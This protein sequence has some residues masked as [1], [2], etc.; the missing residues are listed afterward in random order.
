[1]AFDVGT[2]IGYLDLDTS[3]FQKGF[4][5][6][7]SDLKTFNDS[8]NSTKDRTFAL[9]SA[10]QSVGSTLTQSVTLPLVGIGTAAFA[11]GAEFESQMSRVRAIGEEVGVSF[12]ELEQQ[13]LDLGATTSFSASEAA[14]GMEQL[15]S[16]GFTT[17]EIY[18]AMPGLLD[19]AASSGADLATASE[20]AAAALNG[21]GLEA[22]QAGH[23]ADVFAEAAARTNAQVEDMGEA[24]KYIA[25]VA[26]AMGLSLEET[27][28][29]VGIL[30]D[31]GI[32]GSQAG[33]TL[34]GALT[35]LTKPTKDA[36]AVM[37][38]YGMSFFDA[39]GKMLPLSGVIE[40]LKQGLSGLTDQQRNQALTTLFGQEA[41]SGMLVLMEAGPDKLSELTE[42][43]E[44]VEGSAK[45]MAETMMDNAKGAIEEMFG[46]LETAAINI[47]KIL[48]PMVTSVV[49]WITGLINSFNQM[50]T[51]GQTVVVTIAAI[52]AAAGPLL[53]VLGKVL[54]TISTFPAT[55]T[56]IKSGLA[57]V[58]TGFTALTGAL[59][60]ISAPVLAV[61]AVIGVL[62]AAFKHL[63]DTNEEF[64]SRLTA[65]W[66]DLKGVFSGFADSLLERINSLG[67]EFES[68]TEVLSALWTGFCE[69]LGPLFEGALEAVV[70]VLEIASKLLIGV[71]DLF[72]GLFT[73]DFD[74]FAEGLKGIWDGLWSFVQ[75]IL[76]GAVNLITGIVDTFLGWFDTTWEETWQGV[77]DFF[78]NVWTGITEF[79][80]G[81]LKGISEFFS[82]TI[83]GILTAAGNFVEGVIGFFAKLPSSIWSWLTGSSEKIGAW[84]GDLT[85]EAKAVD[86]DVTTPI[87]VSFSDLSQGIS[88][89]LD[90]ILGNTSD[91]VTKMTQEAESL[92]RS[93]PTTLQD[94]FRSIAESI[95][96]HLTQTS[97]AIESWGFNLIQLSTNI[98]S[99]LLAS[100]QQQLLS[101]QTA[102]S[103][104]LE[105]LGLSIS[106][107]WEQMW[108]DTESALLR[109]VQT[110]ITNFD[111]MRAH[112][113]QT[114]TLLKTSVQQ[115][116]TSMVSWLVTNL[117][118]LV[119]QFKS[120]NN[121]LRT[122]T[123]TTW[124]TM[125][126]TVSTQFSATGEFLLKTLDD[127]RTKMDATWRDISSRTNNTV[128]SMHSTLINGF[129][130]MSNNIADILGTI[131]R[132]VN[133]MCNAVISNCISAM[134]AIAQLEAAAARSSTRTHG[135]GGGSFATGLDYVPR[136]MIVKVHQG[137]SIRT[138]QQ[139]RQDKEQGKPET[140]TKQPLTVVLEVDGRT[141]GKVAISNINDIADTD[142][143]VPLKV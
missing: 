77:S 128:H 98:S 28:A 24:M 90:T 63:W 11:V 13:A 61:V 108:Y 76:E 39:Q 104:G 119:S 107:Y 89:E 141:L 40:Q 143:R 122:N 10:F 49:Q 8:A 22:D 27:A 72:I 135:G 46:A 123:E 41:L 92:G 83:G 105:S 79:F 56:A 30:S 51:F 71:L 80:S 21:F 48:E 110:T 65:I 26:N 97:L 34:R 130:Q 18:A 29:A 31:A 45:A 78:S 16:A 88:T 117:S 70:I 44:T 133:S 23:V 4:K 57:V 59:G 60:T 33:T 96:G 142:G 52:A 127:V 94:G 93:F 99:N 115:V 129:I 53:L 14:L 84:V 101:M 47:Q 116:W 19:L 85:G 75:T 91:W 12:E 3:G 118:N 25:P 137:E 5:T 74:K 140:A 139:T 67:F 136:D 114:F 38:Q 35:R 82:N 69:L 132:N 64:R 109:I 73:G 58:K 120:R 7:L 37:Q 32:K 62:I 124:K 134:N 125:C 9:G 103:S 15:A 17:E 112:S 113:V 2:A 87:S 1:M 138:K 66:D 102:I 131:L 68:L 6:A 86:S 55:L 81:A 54:K 100:T 106:M 43:F 36:T 121:T 42:S 20:I 95:Q 111:M 126:N 50:G